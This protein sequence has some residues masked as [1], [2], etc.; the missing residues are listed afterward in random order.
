IGRGFEGV[1]YPV[2]AKREAVQGIAAYPSLSAL[3]NAPDL[4]VICTPAATVPGLTDECGRLRIMGAV[5]ISA[6]FREVGAE[7]KRLE[8]EVKASAARYAGLRI[9]GPNCLGIMVASMGLKASFAAT[10][11]APGRVAFLS[12]SGALCT[13]VLDWAHATGIGFSHFLSIGNMLDVGMDDLLDYLAADPLTSAVV[14]YIESISE[15]REF[16]SAARAFSREKPIVAYKAGRF[17]D[18]AH[19]AASHTGAMA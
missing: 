7:G 12:Q 10:M 4:A 1:V 13:S 2:N 17:A 11:A 6:G 18:S 3:P 15:A 9:I 5:I 8:E 19:A 16:M 14:L